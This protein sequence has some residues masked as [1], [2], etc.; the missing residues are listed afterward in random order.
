MLVF[1]VDTL[2]S[3]DDLVHSLGILLDVEVAVVLIF[4]SFLG[5]L[6]F[7]L[8]ELLQVDSHEGVLVLCSLRTPLN[9]SLTGIYSTS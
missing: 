5:L 2:S 4:L 6:L 9:D 7:F 3:L 8:L 1:L